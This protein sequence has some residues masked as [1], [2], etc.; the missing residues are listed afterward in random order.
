M[1]KKL[2]PDWYFESFSKI[3][4]GFFKENNIRFL[5]C[6]I[7]NTLVSYADSLPTPEVLSFF[8]LA[9]KENVKI[10]FASNNEEKRVRRFARSAGKPAV[11]KAKK[12]LKRGIRA[13]LNKLGA[14]FEESAMLGDQLLTDGLAAKNIGIRMILVNPLRYDPSG[15]LFRMKR[16]IEKPILKSYLKHCPINST[17]PSGK[18]KN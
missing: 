6:D 11:H 13:A 17:L 12:P 3:P 18:E 5:I 1:L 7:D 8:A 9:E 2:W 10:A 15:L 4:A 14:S 16:Q